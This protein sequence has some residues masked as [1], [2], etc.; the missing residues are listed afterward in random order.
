MHIS[1]ISSLDQNFKD[2]FNEFSMRIQELTFEASELHDI[3]RVVLLIN[4]GTSCECEKGPLANRIRK[5]LGCYTCI[6]GADFDYSINELAEEGLV[7]V[8]GEKVRLT[9]KGAKL[10]K[11]LK[12]LLFKREPILEIVAGL[13]DGSVTSLIVILSAFLGGLGTSMTVFAATLT[14]AAVA[15]TG[16]SSLILGAKTEDIADLISIKTLMEYGFH[17]IPDQEERDKSLMLIKSL[18]TVLKKD[19]SRANFFSALLS[20]ATIL[21]SG[22][23]PITLYIF[24]PR[25]LN[26]I[27]SLGFVGAIVLIFL[28]RYRS[29]KTGI[30]WKATLIETVGIILVSVVLSLFIGG[31][32]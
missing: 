18:F 1:A 16:F 8:Q 4:F 23:I 26:I 14:L 29:R 17:N 11:E 9:D 2:L 22:L 19:I 3:M 32:I 15:L 21:F 25:P 6:D 24:L 31:T 7:T 28:V 5:F 13:T 27:I 12:G 20:A 30:H 10:S